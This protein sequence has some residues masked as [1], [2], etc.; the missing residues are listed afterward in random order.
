M[1]KLLDIDTDTHIFVT[2][3]GRQPRTL[4]NT[5]FGNKIADARRS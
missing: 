1:A 3:T 2:L 4:R 5:K